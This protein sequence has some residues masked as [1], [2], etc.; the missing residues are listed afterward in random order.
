MSL[1]PNK[2]FSYSFTP[3]QI[4]GEII[5]RPILQV[6]L[7]HKAIEFPTGVLIDSGA[8]YSIIQREIVE[9]A[10]G[11]DVSKIKKCGETCGITGKTDV[12]EI[13]IEM[14]F[15]TERNTL[16]EKIPFRVSLDDGKDP[17]ITL[18]GRDPFF[19]KYRV[20]FR[21]GYTDDPTLGK[22]VLYP[23]THKR[24]ANS[25]KRPLKYKK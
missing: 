10:F 20:D 6:V 13:T 21:M 22:F 25:F 17:P 12:G 19:Y 11:I 7:M 24:K 5:L 15:G 14:R 8:D 18:L 2:S 1:L 3:I 23:E 16:V 4:Q 9:D